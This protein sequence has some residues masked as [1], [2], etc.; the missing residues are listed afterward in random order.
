MTLTAPASS[1]EP[2]S[3][4]GTPIAKSANPSLLKS[5]FTC[6]ALA[7]NEGEEEDKTLVF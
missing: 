2:T 1:R 3:S 4:F 7:C 5:A 6:I